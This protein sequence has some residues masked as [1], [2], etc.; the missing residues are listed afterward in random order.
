MLL[1]GE[2]LCGIPWGVFQTITTAYAAEVTPVAL[3]PYLTTYVNLCWVFG[4]FIGSG[5]LRGLL[6][7]TDQWGYRIPFAIQWVWPVP[8]L[9]GIIFAPESPWW[10]VR[11]GRYSDAEKA[12]KRLT[13]RS[14][15]EFD[16]GKTIAMMIHTDEIEK[17]TTA[18]A[19][20]WDCFRGTDF[21]RTEIACMVWMTQTFCGDGIAGYSTQFY[22]QAGLST[23]FSFDL[24][25]VQYAIGAVGVFCAWIAMAYLGRRTLYLIGLVG[26]DIC[27]LI[28]GF[29]SLA[30][31]SNK[32]APWVTGSVMLIFTFIYDCTIGPVCYC[33]VA[34]IPS[35][36]LRNKTIVLARNSYNIIG[37]FNNIVTPRM[38][39]PTGWNWAGKSG[40]FWAGFCTFA[41]VWTWFRLPEPKGKTFGELDILFE[42]KVN[43]RKFKSAVVDVFGMDVANDNSLTKLEGSGDEK[44]QVV[45]EEDISNI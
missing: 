33:L 44:T 35:S 2:I 27:L 23:V 12:L 13:T 38:L 8:L 42:R 16:P 29:V 18:G 6:S 32:A 40:F 9:I 30:P 11:K 17:E 39:N 22:E 36:R 7:F 10:L 37:I 3:R 25:M 20:Y 14:V 43:A 45:M 19:S 15:D 31:S 21:R 34:E 5:V 1:V 26:L 4:Q 28:I 24:N 41:L